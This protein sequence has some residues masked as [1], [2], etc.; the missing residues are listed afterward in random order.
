MAGNPQ[1]RQYSKCSLVR[2]GRS[3]DLLETTNKGGG[4]W[5]ERNKFA[6]G[7]FRNQRRA[8]RWINRNMK[9]CREFRDE[10]SSS[11]TTGNSGL[12]AA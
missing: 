5:E 8:K 11:A 12:K 10:Q 2:N 1:V 3:V 7:E 4:R 9:N 6:V